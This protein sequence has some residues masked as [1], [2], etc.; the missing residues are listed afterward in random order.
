[1]EPDGALGH[2]IGRLFFT[3]K[4]PTP[5]AREGDDAQRGMGAN[6]TVGSDPSRGQG[7]QGI[8]TLSTTWITPLDCMTLAIVI[9]AWPPLA[10]MTF[11]P[12][13]ERV[14]VSGSPWTVR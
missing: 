5:T 2:P 8:S 14:K 1:M 9:I 3:A 4:V 13:P 10:S 6:G 12:R 11:Q 7:D